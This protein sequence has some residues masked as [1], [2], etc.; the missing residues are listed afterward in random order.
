MGKAVNRLSL[1]WQRIKQTKANL[2]LVV[3][4]CAL[5]LLAVLWRLV[6][7]PV[8][9]VVPTDY[10]R[11]QLF[12]GTVTTYH[13]LPG[14]PLLEGEPSEIRF[15]TETRTFNPLGLSTS[16]TAVFEIDSWVMDPETREQFFEIEKR[17][18]VDRRDGR[19]VEHENAGVD[20]SGYYVVF[21][22][23]SP[24]GDVPYWSEQTGKTHPAEFQGEGEINGFK[25]Y[26]YKVEYNDQPVV[27]AVPGYPLEPVEGFEERLKDNG[28]I[29]EGGE[30]DKPELV[31]SAVTELAI[32]PRMGT[33]VALLGH[34]STVSMKTAADDGTAAT[35][36]LYKVEYAESGPCIGDGVTF[37]REEV[38]KYSLQFCYIP[39]GLLLLGIACLLV[40][41][42]VGLEELLPPVVEDK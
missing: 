8:I 21:P 14:P 5:I 1:R 25:V 19:M 24:R 20:R 39:L 9:K 22:F 2:V 6:I 17:Y 42:L 31:E 15:Q 27:G 13:D 3:A 4:G 38:S 30:G 16:D 36:P 23:D 34:E 12:E 41:S 32:E 10:D 7:A 35:T 11:L 33:V 37:A 18:A 28:L 40:G 29:P 26:N